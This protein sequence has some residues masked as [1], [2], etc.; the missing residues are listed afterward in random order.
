M[1]L[2]AR[3]RGDAPQLASYL[4]SM[5]DNEHVELHEVRGFMSDDLHEAFSEAEAVA[6][7]TKC[8]N[9]LFSMSL[10]PPEDQTVNREVFEQ[11]IEQIER[12]LDLIDHPRALVFHEK[13]GRRHA[14]AVWS[15]I[16]SETMRAKNMAFYKDK[17]MDVS[18]DL[19]LEHGWDMP[20]GMID[21]NMRSPLNYSLAKYQQAKRAKQDPRLI[22]AAIQECWKSSDSGASLEKALEEKGFFL[23][24]GNR[25]AVLAVDVRGNEFSLSRA[26]GVKEKDI[27]ARIPEKD[28]LSSLDDRRAMIAGRMTKKLKSYL[29]EVDAGHRRSSP[30]LEYKRQQMQARH[31]EERKTEMRR[32]EQRDQ[33]EAMMRASRLPIGFKGIWSR[34]TG[35]FS[36]IKQ[37]NE[38]DAL[39]AW[40]RDRAEKDRLIARQLDERQRLQQSIRKQREDRSKEVAQIRKEIAAYIA[41]KPGHI[42]S[43]EV[44]RRDPASEKAKEQTRDNTQRE[45]QRQRERRRDRNRGPDFEP[46]L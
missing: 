31:A 37:Q 29:H 38:M 11:A 10:N 3:E 42:P 40:E 26:C 20:N 27:R 15:R 8:K 32:I 1:I 44:A 5:R 35:G 43:L 34:I 24:E 23:A 13:E 22:K 30:A 4:L 39:R 21:R 18:R 6:S 7:G 25:R 2:K 46:G 28:K 12:K 14:H 33:R 45:R 41:M 17:L 36:K 19:Y 9:H 16:D